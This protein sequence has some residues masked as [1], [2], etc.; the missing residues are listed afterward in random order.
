MRAFLRRCYGAITLSNRRTVF[1]YDLS[2]LVF[3]ALIA[4]LFRSIPE[5]YTGFRYEVG[6]LG[7]PSTYIFDTYRLYFNAAWFGA[8]GGV[9]ISLKGVY[10]NA[11][12]P[13]WSNCYNLWHLGRPFSGAATGFI[14]ALIFMAISTTPPSRIVIYM[15]AFLLGTQ[16]ARFF[17]FLF[18]LTRLFVQVPD[19][20]RSQIALRLIGVVPPHGKAGTGLVVQG[21]SF[22]ANAVIKFGGLAVDGLKVLDDGKTAIGQ[23]PNLGTQKRTVDVTVFNPGTGASSV[24]PDGFTYEV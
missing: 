1:F 14:A 8:L 2:I 21:Q 19:Q 13:P 12:N 23:V 20:L 10:D 17:N 11:C 4:L 6:P 22:E 24:L 18:E 16:E 15:I 7:K 5:F 9:V 3:L